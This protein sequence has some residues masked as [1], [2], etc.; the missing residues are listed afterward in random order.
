MKHFKFYTKEDI[1][2]L[3]KVRRYETK[4]GERLKHVLSEGNWAEQLQQSTA[5]FVVLG[6]PEDIGVKG[7]Y[8][9]GGAD[10]NWLPFL[11]SFVNVQSND[12]FT[13]E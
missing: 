9:I 3:T 6:I 12:F 7:N 1:L 8:G 13:G 5:K 4:I 10:T 2:S 11:S